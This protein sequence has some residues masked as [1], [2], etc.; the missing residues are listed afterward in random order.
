MTILNKATTIPLTQVQIKLD[1]HIEKMNAEGWQLMSAAPINIGIEE[2]FV[3]FWRKE[4]E[5][6]NLNFKSSVNLQ[7]STGD[8][9]KG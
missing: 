3:L 1:P 6:V 5:P 4:V 2:V 7:G 9:T 8:G